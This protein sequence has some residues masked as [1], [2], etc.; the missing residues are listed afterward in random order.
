MIDFN[1]DRAGINAAGLSRVFSVAFKFRC[2]P[3]A[4][5]SKGIEVALKV[6]PLPVGGEYAFPL[7]I[8]SIGRSTVEHR[9]GSL[10]F[11]GHKSA[12]SRITD[13]PTSQKLQ[14]TGWPEA[15]IHASDPIKSNLFWMSRLNQLQHFDERELR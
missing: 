13:A 4:Q 6:S 10:G 9:A 12:G 14:G 5:E 1:P 7:G 2:G 8:G 15:R 3:R 11:R